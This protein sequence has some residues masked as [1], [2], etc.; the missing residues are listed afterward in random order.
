MEDAKKCQPLDTMFK[1]KNKV[2]ISKK[3]PSKDNSHMDEQ[4]DLEIDFSASTSTNINQ[5]TN[6]NPNEILQEEVNNLQ[7]DVSDNSDDNDSFEY[8][9]FIKPKEN[10]LHICFKYH[11]QIPKNSYNV[12]FN[13]YKVF[14]RPNQ[15]SRQWLT[16][17]LQKKSLYC[18][19][20]LAFSND[21]NRFTQG[22]SE[23]KHTY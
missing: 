13:I 1:N 5:N 18:S 9:F 17:S 10:E 23:W 2:I 11:P 12:P 6:D 21:G 3:L 8:N 14:K 20:C 15:T 22:M 7:V 19:V 16:Y 4:Q